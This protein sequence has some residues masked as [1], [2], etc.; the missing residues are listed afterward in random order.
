MPP[1]KNWKLLNRMNQKR[2]ATIILIAVVIIVI[3]IAVYFVFN[4][5]SE[6]PSAQQ[7]SHQNQAQQKTQTPQNT[8][9]NTGPG[10]NNNLYANKKFN[11]QLKVPD[12]WRLARLLSALVEV[13]SIIIAKYKDE[14]GD[15]LDFSKNQTTSDLKK[16][17]EFEKRHLEERSRLVKNWGSAQSEWIIFTNISPEE[18]AKFLDTAYRKG[19]TTID[20]PPGNTVT[21]QVT[22]E[23]VDLNFVEKETEQSTHKKI[24]TNSGYTG[25]YTRIKRG[26]INVTSAHIPMETSIGLINGEM[27][28]SIFIESRQKSLTQEDFLRLTNSLLL[29][30]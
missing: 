26:N 4:K 12:G 5:K 18:E 2:F 29:Q 25:I 8:S 28:R 15:A 14:V 3:S 21:I 19:E 23:S 30:E 7:V 27:A 10:L 22:S 13:N 1:K 17:E 6:A 11:Y 24:T 20:F 16:L 9:Q